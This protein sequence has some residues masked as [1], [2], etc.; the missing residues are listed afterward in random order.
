MA[1]SAAIIAWFVLS[2]GSARA[3][4]ETMN[5]DLSLIFDGSLAWFGDDEPDQRGGHDPSRTG[6]NFNQLELHAG[7]SVDPFFR[8][9]ANIVF[10]QFGVEVEEAYATTLALPA[11]LQVRAG[12]F[13]TRFGRA[14]ATHP[15]AWSF[16]DQPLVFGKLF[17]SEGSRGLGLE[18][19]WLSPLPWYAELVASASQAD[20]EC[21]ARS[22]QG[23]TDLGVHGLEDFL[24]TLALKQFWDVSDAVGLGLGLSTQLGPNASGLGNRTVILGADLHLRWRP[25]GSTARTAVDLAVEA[26]YRARE[27]PGRV[28][29]DGGGFAELRWQ[30]DPE[31]ALAA[32]HELVTGLDDDP[33]DPEWIDLRQRTALA[34]DFWP[35]HFSRLRLQ[36]G[37]DLPRWEETPGWMAMLGLEV[38]IGAHGAHSY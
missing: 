13:L 22:F 28:A 24:Y 2:A 1:R 7:A 14:N 33:L 32:R 25:P 15:H 11:G 31:W 5:P 37:A 23:G 16:L 8:F 30:V 20:G 36:L 27:L 4:P 10:A 18:V 26:L 38:V 17:G 12:Q 29:E 19:S 35:S 21:C 9:E 3:V 6:F 34:V